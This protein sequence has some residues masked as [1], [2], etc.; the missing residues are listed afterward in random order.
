MSS[1][2]QNFINKIYPHAVEDMKQSNVLASL[3]IAQ[4]ILE[5]GWGESRLAQ[6]GN[7]LFGIKKGDGWNGKTISLNGSQWRVYDSW[8]GGIQDHSKLLQKPRYA[9]VIQT[10]DYKVACEEVQLAGYCTESDYSQK[11]IRLIEQYDLAKYDVVETEEFIPYRVV[12][13]CDSLAIREKDS[14]GSCRTGY[15]HKGEVFTIV[16]ESNG[17]LKL[18]S[19]KGWISANQKYI[20]KMK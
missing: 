18:K 17:L 11:L 2:T 1:K 9:K 19:G 7:N 5:S 20:K 3:T 14:F 4:A 6:E 8:L 12:V 13:I 16:G 15:V 10:K